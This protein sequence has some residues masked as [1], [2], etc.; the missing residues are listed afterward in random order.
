MKKIRLTKR[1]IQVNVG[2]K[3]NPDY[4]GAGD[5]VELTNE[6]A[7]KMIK[8]GYGEEVKETKSNAKEGQ[9]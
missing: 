6:A 4:K 3:E 9:S 1:D 7:E 5:V 8:A 2:T